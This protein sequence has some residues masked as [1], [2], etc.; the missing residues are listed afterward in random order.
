MTMSP[1][2]AGKFPV[3]SE[4]ERLETLASY[5]VLDTPPEKT[6]DDFARL[7]A[8]V[9][10]TPIGLISLVDGNRQWFK[11]KL[12][13]E[14]SETPRSI[15]FCS[16]A[17]RDTEVFV[18]PDA[19]DDKRFADNPLVTSGPMIRFY[20][21]APLIDARGAALGT[22]C[23]LDQKPRELSEAER[24]ALQILSNH[25]MTE[26]ELR[27]RLLGSINA[28]Q[29]RYAM[30]EPLKRAIAAREFVLYYQP[31]VNLNSGRIDSVEALLRWCH[32]QR[33]LVPPE[34]FI[35]LLETA[36]LIGAA[37]SW[38]VAEVTAARRDWHERSI[39]V[40]RIA[41][42][43]SPSQLRD[44]QFIRTL[45]QLR[46]S[47][48]TGDLCLDVE[49]TESVMMERSEHVIP[50]LKDLR[51]AGVRIA[52]DDFGTGHSSL[53]S[54]AEL[55]LDCVKIDRSLVATMTASPSRMALVS[56]IIHLAH[57]LKLTVVAEGVET[58]EQQKLLRLLTCDAMQGY[59]HS[60]PMP[61]VA[62]ESFLEPPGRA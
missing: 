52:L 22:L 1:S 19:R 11:A 39:P 61:K 3:A 4:A 28:R 57:G 32:P 26:L 6:F 37:G 58:S 38:V 23:V 33:G 7:A 10:G 20:A 34:E 41:I 31:I 56:T 15:A 5:D 17:I 59:V 16:H 55:P 27:R 35:P 44:A 48:Q 24:Q 51:A 45:T 2:D 30:L 54:L 29:L 62:L 8:A 50:I 49:V 47:A 12:G 60:R 13:L 40:P 14:V 46:E 43:L 21:G 36:G 25:V 9:V 42:N 18:V 53:L